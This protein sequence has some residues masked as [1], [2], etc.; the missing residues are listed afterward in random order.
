MGKI[1]GF[2]HDHG[3]QFLRRRYGHYPVKGNLL[4]NSQQDIA[5][6]RGHIDQEVIE[7]SPVHLIEE[8]ADDARDHGPAPRYGHVFLREHEIG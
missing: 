6:A 2:A 4:E 8:L 1:D 7:L 5:C 3:H